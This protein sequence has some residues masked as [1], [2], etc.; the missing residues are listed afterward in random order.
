[1]ATILHFS[2]IHFG[3][4]QAPNWADAVLSDIDRL[5]PTV[6][7]VSGDLT[8][9]ARASQ[10]RAA[11][12]FLDR[13]SAPLVVVPGNHDVPLWNVFDRFLSPREKYRRW[14]TGDLNPVFESDDIFVMGIDTTRSFTIKGGRV[15]SREIDRMRNRI[16]QVA[17]DRIKVIVAH[18]PFVQPP[19][20]E[21]EETVG[22]LRRALALFKERG[23]DIVLT[24][25]LHQSHSHLHLEGG[26]AILLAQ[27]GTAA[28]LR[29]RGAERQRNSFNFIEV[30]RQQVRVTSHLYCEASGSFTPA[31]SKQWP[32]DLFSLA[33]A[34]TPGA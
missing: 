3:G 18:H 5:K 14:I 8:Q 13:I 12:A 29:G 7:A 6:V 9:R 20:F 1:M 25:H 34:D 22:G 26:R 23:V 33:R 21:R 11:R 17:G 10:F 2:D 16:R 30:T 4:P 32:R 24:G 15:S 19:G 28:S 31:L 27:A